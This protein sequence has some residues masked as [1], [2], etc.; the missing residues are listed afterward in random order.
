MINKNSQDFIQG[1]KDGLVGTAFVVLK[2]IDGSDKGDKRV[3]NPELE[4]MRRVL[5]SWRDFIVETKDAGG[6]VGKKAQ[7]I[8][9]ESRKTMEA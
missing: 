4:K 5:L 8:L 2:V 6:A 7:E 9:V 3:A 1:Q